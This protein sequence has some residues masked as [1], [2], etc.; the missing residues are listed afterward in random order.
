[1]I[2]HTQLLAV[3]DKNTKVKMFLMPVLKRDKVLCFQGISRLLMLLIS[4]VSTRLM[5]IIRS[6]QLFL[7]KWPFPPWTAPARLCLEL[8]MQI[9]SY[10][11]AFWTRSLTRLSVFHYKSKPKQAHETWRL[12]VSPVFIFI[13]VFGSFRKW[14]LG[15]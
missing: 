3:A 14:L 9:L 10:T 12:L 7:S 15:L 1:M 8:M 4:D 2:K 5:I 11:Q 6:V 13:K